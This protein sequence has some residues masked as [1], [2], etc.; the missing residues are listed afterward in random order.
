MFLNLTAGHSGGI[1]RAYP[2]LCIVKPGRKRPLGLCNPAEPKLYEFLDEVVKEMSAIFPGPYIHC[3]AD[4]VGMAA[5]RNDPKC[6]AWM[7]T[8]KKSLR[9]LSAYF[10]CK[11]PVAW[12]EI[13]HAK[14]LPSDMTITSW[15]GTAPGI[16]TAAAR[17]Y[18]TVMCP[19]SELYYD[20][21]NSRSKKILKATLSIQLL[22]IRVTTLSRHRHISV[23]QSKS[24]L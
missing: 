12:D 10:T 20:R 3:G 21:I 14:G 13:L 17:G 5:W 6:K 16:I 7:H 18:N 15:R 9:D 24:I 11:K 8:N 2:E 1:A 22:L 4:E 23:K 19:V